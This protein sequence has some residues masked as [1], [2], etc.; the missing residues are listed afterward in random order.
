MY[1]VVRTNK[2]L[3]TVF[4]DVSVGFFFT[5]RQDIISLKGHREGVPV[6]T[7]TNFQKNAAADVVREKTSAHRFAQYV[8]RVGYGT[9][10]VMAIYVQNPLVYLKKTM[11]QILF[12]CPGQI[13]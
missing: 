7:N 6:D 5:T 12:D 1:Y 9:H 13:K 4:I 10:I 2:K 3:Q 11:L 8:E